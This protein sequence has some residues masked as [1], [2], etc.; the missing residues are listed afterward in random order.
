[1]QITD[2]ASL[3]E[4]GDDLI[5]AKENIEDVAISHFDDSLGNLN[6]LPEPMKIFQSC[7]LGVYYVTKL[8]T[9]DNYIPIFQLLG[10]K[11]LLMQMQKLSR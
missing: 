2:D 9:A 1:M 10:R 7:S 8:S 5:M 11:Q 3:G 4:L 6:C